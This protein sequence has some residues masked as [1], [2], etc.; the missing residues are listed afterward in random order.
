MRRSRHLWIAVGAVV[1]CAIGGGLFGPSLLATDDKIPDHYKTFSA[2][3]SAIEARYV[4]TVESDRVVYSAIRGMLATLDPHSS[5]FDPREYAQMRQ[6]Q[7]GR[8]YGLGI[9]IASIDGD[10]I[11]QSVFEGSPA[12]K[13]GV[14]RGDVIAKIAGEDAKGWNTEKAMSKLRGPKGTTVQL[15]I[16]RRGYE[17]PIPLDV[18]RDE[19]TIPTVPAYFMLDATTGYIRHKDWGENTD[20]DMRHALRELRAQGMK[21]LLYDIRS[22]PGGP[23]DQAIK[24]TNEFLPRGRMIVYTRGRIGNSDVDYHATED[25]EF[26]DVPMVVLVNRNS[27][28]ASEIFT[29]ALQDHDRAFIVGETTFGKALVQSVYRIAGNAGL[30]LTTAHYFT[31]SGRMIQRPWDESFDE[32]LTYTQRDQDANKPHKA[33]ELTHT[34]GGRSVYGGGGIEPDKYVAGFPTSADGIGFSPSQFGR[35]LFARQE[36]ENYAQKFMASGD[37]RI[38]QQATGRRAVSPNFTVDEGMIAEFR[39]QLKADRIKID[40]Q[41]FQKD[42]DFI[43]AMMRYRIDEAVF[44]FV[45]AEKHLIAV[46]PQAQVGLSMFPEAQSLLTLDRA[47]SKVAQK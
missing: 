43:K 22:N 32:Y 40:D 45:E 2:A 13:L 23:L 18:T 37:S 25:S 36:F 21:R 41:A 39:D 10:I 6:R 47:N 29:G 14:R 35:M 8:N 19:V 16:K 4:D 30:A 44:G 33:S 27:A 17:Q 42:L 12:F 38:A 11:A 26:T 7:E 28:S 46:D 24:V 34:D 5:F 1:V 3:L 20:R 9:T 15:A 31:P